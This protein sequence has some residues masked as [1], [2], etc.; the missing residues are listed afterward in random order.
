MGHSE[1]FWSE[2]CFSLH[3]LFFPIIQKEFSYTNLTST[4]LLQKQSSFDKIGGSLRILISDPRESEITVPVHSYNSKYSKDLPIVFCQNWTVFSGAIHTIS[5]HISCQCKIIV[6]WNF[7]LKPCKWISINRCH[8]KSVLESPR[9]LWISFNG[10][11]HSGH[12][13]RSEF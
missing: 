3:I 11:G 10:I 4:W 1:I 13:F 2:A 7:E 12:S 5:S 8:S 9:N 6:N